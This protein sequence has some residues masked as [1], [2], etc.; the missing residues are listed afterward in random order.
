MDGYAEK[1][2]SI[3]N[4]L[5]DLKANFYCELCDKQYHKHQEFD[6]HINSYDHAHKQVSREI[7]ARHAAQEVPLFKAPRLKGPKEDVVTGKDEKFENLRCEVMCSPKT[8]TSNDSAEDK[9]ADI[10]LDGEVLKDGSCCFVGSQNQVQ[11]P[12]SNSS[13]VNNRAGVSFCFSKKALLKLDSSASVFNESVEEVNEYNQFLHHKAKQMSVSFRHYAHLNE[14]A[15]ETSALTQPDETDMSLPDNMP[16]NPEKLKD[17]KGSQENSKEHIETAQSNITAK[18][19]SPDTSYTDQPSQNEVNVPT[20]AEPTSETTTEDGCQMQ[21]GVPETGSSKHTVADAILIEHF[22]NLLS[23]KHADD[24]SSCDSKEG[25]C[26]ASNDVHVN[27]SDSPAPEHSLG[28]SVNTNTQAKALSFLSVLSKDGNTILQW[29]TELVLFTKTQPSISYACNPLYFDFKCSPKNKTRKPND[30]ETGKYKYGNERSRS[31]ED[32]TSGVNV[33]AVVESRMASPSFEPKNDEKLDLS[34]KD[35]ESSD[36]DLTSTRF[37]E[38]A[39]N[40]EESQISNYSEKCF[41]SDSYHSRK[42]K[43]SSHAQSDHCVVKENI[44]SKEKCKRKRYLHRDGLLM[45][46]SCSSKM[47]PMSRQEDCCSWENSAGWKDSDSDACSDTSHKTSSSQLSYSSS[48]MSSGSSCRYKD[49]NRSSTQGA[50]LNGLNWRSAKHKNDMSSKSDYIKDDKELNCKWRHHKHNTFCE[51]PRNE[52]LEH[53]LCSKH[54]RNQHRSRKKENVLEIDP[55]ANNLNSIQ[56]GNTEGFVTVESRLN[57]S[58]AS[59]EEITALPNPSRSPVPAVHYD[60]SA[61]KDFL[62]GHSQDVTPILVNCGESTSEN[63]VEPEN[64]NALD[65]LPSDL[66]LEAKKTSVHTVEG[67][68]RLKEH[69]MDLN[70]PLESPSPLRCKT[71]DFKEVNAPLHDKE[72]SSSDNLDLC[73]EDGLISNCLNNGLEDC[74]V[75]VLTRTEV[76]G[77]KRQFIPAEQPIMQSPDPGHLNFS[78]PLPSLRHPGEIFSP[79][80]KEEPLRLGQPDVNTKSSLVDGNLKCFYDSTMQDFRKMDPRLHHK[81][82]GP[83][84]AQQPVTFSPDEVDKY[85]ILQ[86]QAQQHMQKQLLTKHFKALPPNG[87]AVFSTA[88]TIQPVSIQHHPSITTIHHALM[89][90]YAVTASMHSHVNHFPLPHLNHFPQAPFSPINLSSSLTPTLFPTPPPIIGH[91]LTHPLHLV[92]TAAINPPHLTIQAI[93]HATLIPTIITPHPNTGMHPTLHLHPLIHP[94]FQGQEFHHH[95]GP[96]H[97]H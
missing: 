77:Q 2:K 64:D 78:C 86:M 19:H 56:E 43:K 16:A 31:Y 92:S 95:S 51:I 40:E 90:R 57:N 74:E 23:Q 83:P 58:S 10:S 62:L 29:P 96:G 13:S 45:D 3:A 63:I 82:S 36:W 37:K 75:L 26:E 89:Q 22:S 84:L 15:A 20:E 50:S 85:K 76:E 7:H 4:A 52:Y 49:L 97:L 30:R 47:S 81:S 87:S 24:E 1:G 53:W 72:K 91:T 73:T 66:L 67:N 59:S 6:N 27:P 60:G 80:T 55:V 8:I 48:S 93:P 17:D 88:Q 46:K 61:T 79:E 35:M 25:N 11:V 9:K 12:L 33:E 5:E 69:D 38:H 71:V 42:R 28:D 54:A 94:L 41:I 68:N 18:M 32:R 14:S 44:H 65:Q 34:E 21:S 70:E 39:K